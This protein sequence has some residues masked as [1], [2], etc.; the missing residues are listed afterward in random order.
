M[1]LYCIET[2]DFRVKVHTCA[3]IKKLI[4][5]PHCLLGL[6]DPLG[7]QHLEGQ[8]LL[9]VL[10]DQ[11]F[12]RDLCPPAR[13]LSYNNKKKIRKSLSKCY[14]VNEIELYNY[15]S[16]PYHLLFQE[17][18]QNLSDQMDPAEVRELSSH[19]CCH[20]FLEATT[21][22]YITVILSSFIKIL[23]N[24]DKISLMYGL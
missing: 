22:L 16:I 2:D 7:L 23:H 11:A 3:N 18:P 1:R 15:F 12:Q 21:M 19:L 4:S 17:A 13:T 8:C 5:T 10:E 6:V 24:H 9:L 20:Q 14:C